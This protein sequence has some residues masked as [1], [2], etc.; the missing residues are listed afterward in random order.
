MCLL[1]CQVI[2]AKTKQVKFESQFEYLF[3]KMLRITQTMKTFQGLSLIQHFKRA[4]TSGSLTST[5]RRRYFASA[6]PPP[7]GSL[8]PLLTSEAPDKYLEEMIDSWTKNQGGNSMALKFLV[9]IFGQTFWPL[10][11]QTC[12]LLGQLGGKFWVWMYDYSKN[13]LN[14][15][16]FTL[17]VLN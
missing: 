4:S 12:H 15:F 1:N 2:L 17:R 16:K 10:I 14:H 9:P 8:E 7:L 13:L 3:L 5:V 6:P 11:E